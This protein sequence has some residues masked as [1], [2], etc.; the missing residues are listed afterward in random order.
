MDGLGKGVLWKDQPVTFTIYQPNNR[1][2][3]GI[4]GFFL[5][6]G[7]QDSGLYPKYKKSPTHLIFVYVV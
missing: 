1:I 2:V 4:M 5:G 3:G 7:I 6:G